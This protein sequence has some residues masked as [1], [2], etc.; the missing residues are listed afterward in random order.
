MTEKWVSIDRHYCE[1]CQCWTSGTKSAIV[2]HE[3]SSRH[4]I[5]L[6]KRLFEMRLKSEKKKEEEIQIDKELKAIEYA[7]R[8]A[9]LFDENDF[10]SSS[11]QEPPLTSVTNAKKKVKLTNQL[12]QQ[13]QPKYIKT[14]ASIGSIEDSQSSN[15]WNSISIGDF[16]DTCK[17]QVNFIPDDSGIINRPGFIFNT[18][19]PLG[20]GY[21]KKD[22][23]KNDNKNENINENKRNNINDNIISATHTHTHTHAYNQTQSQ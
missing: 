3:M 14:S 13:Q 10:Q 20:K 11:Q 5:N 22:N 7:A 19:G 1:A 8:V 15:V 9:S 6:D 17:T 23:N 4:K 21:Y 12:Q 18:K 2:H 16:P